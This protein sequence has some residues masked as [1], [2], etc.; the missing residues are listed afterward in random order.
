MAKLSAVG[1]E[2][3][4]VVK[5]K[6]VNGL[7]KLKAIPLSA[8]MKASY[9][10]PFW[11]NLSIDASGLCTGYNYCAPYWEARG[12]LSLVLPGLSVIGLSAGGG[13]HGFVYSANGSVEFQS[14]RLY[15]A[16]ENGIGGVIPYE[17]IPLK[18]NNNTFLIGLIYLIK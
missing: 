5:P 12:G 3:L 17:D 6:A 13:T 8:N 1:E 10:M 7:Y 14:F 2:I 9:Q 11:E 16:F 4:A 18:A 15:A